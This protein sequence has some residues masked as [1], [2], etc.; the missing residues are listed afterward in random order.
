MADWVIYKDGAYW[1]DAHGWRA[2]AQATH[3]TPAEKT[4]I[5]IG[6]WVDLDELRA[7]MG[8]KAKEDIPEIDLDQIR[9]SDR[10][11]TLLYGESSLSV[12]CQSIWLGRE[13]MIKF[14][15]H[16][17]N[18]ENMYDGREALINR[19]PTWLFIMAKK[20]YLG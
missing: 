2:L 14:M 13:A 16:A 8:D 6:K 3:F 15:I 4:S 7:W 1:S 5:P 11:H 19:V 20:T 18:Y 10:M 17:E 12:V 9:G